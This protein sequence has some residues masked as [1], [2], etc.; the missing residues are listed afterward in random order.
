[1]PLTEGRLIAVFGS[2]GDRDREKR[3][4]MGAVAARCADFSIFTDEDPRHEPSLA[5]I[6][7]IAAGA[8]AA[9]R[10]EGQDFLRLADRRAAIEQAIDLA[11]AGDVILLAGKGHERSILVA[12]GS[13]PW[14]EEG[15]ARDAL[16]GRGYRRDD[17]PAG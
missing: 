16:R 11:G 15:A 6:D 2:A 8:V 5:I 7:E 12:G 1:R 17:Q 4:A 3:P 13:V 9:G 14:D 10:R